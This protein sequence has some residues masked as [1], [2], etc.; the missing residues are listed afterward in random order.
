MSSPFPHHYRVGLVRE[1]PRAVLSDGVKPPITGGPP[2]EFGGSPQWWSPEHLLMAAANLCFKATFDAIAS[3][4]HLIVEGFDSEVTGVLDKT[5]TGVEFVSVT[6]AVTVNVAP[7]QKEL[8]E[9]LLHSAK[10]H[11]IVANSL[12][13]AITLLLRIREEVALP[14]G[15]A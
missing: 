3:R 12:K 1:G 11:C 4:A 6:L 9:R 10:K 13:P 5:A 15:A 8:A 14:S 2:P 7:D